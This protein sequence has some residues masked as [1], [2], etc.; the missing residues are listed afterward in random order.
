[1]SADVLERLLQ[2]CEAQPDSVELRQRCGDFCL[3]IDDLDAAE[4]HYRKALEIHSQRTDALNGL[5]VVLARQ[6]RLPEA[7]E[8]LRQVLTLDPHCA[9]AHHN[10]GIALTEQGHI[11]LAITSLQSAIEVDPCYV[12]AHL[13]LANALRT[14]G[15]LK[16]AHA[17]YLSA[18]SL[19]P[20]NVKALHDL[21]TLRTQLK[22]P[23]EA[24]VTLRQVIRLDRDHVDG[25]NSLGL[26]QLAMGEFSEAIASFEHALGINPHWQICHVNLGTAYK[27]SG[28]LNEAIAQ[29]EFAIALDPSNASAH[30]NLSLALLQ[31]GEYERGFAEYEWRQRRIQSPPRTFR[32]PRWDGRSALEGKTLFVHSE[33]GLGDTIQFL[34]FAR[35]LKDGSQAARLVFECPSPLKIIA[36]TC[37]GVDICHGDNEPCPPFDAHFPLLSAPYVFRTTISTIPDRFP[38]LAADLERIQKWRQILESRG[39]HNFRI[40]ICWQ[41]NP[42]HQLDRF[43]SVSLSLFRVLANIDGVSLYCLQRGPG[44]EQLDESA[45]RSLGVI[46]LFERCDSPGA[47]EWAETAAIVRNLDLVICVDT[48]IAHL[49]GSM[50]VAT[51]ILLSTCPDWRWLTIRSDSPWYP[52]V[53]LFRQKAIGRWDGVF[54]EVRTELELELEQAPQHT[55]PPMPCPVSQVTN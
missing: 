31:A 42:H 21:G 29:Y 40:G 10:L 39:D 26:T 52:S 23:E 8:T 2:Q 7:M 27:E 36:A 38:Y 20:G 35:A 25:W 47:E 13:N 5:A 28:R 6:H 44:T 22:R 46:E 41:G 4:L 15:R 50:N 19:Q 1:M 30:W 9:R 32:E 17:R 24:A 18:I 45:N 16:E 54:D 49:A 48:A 11:E 53:R 12:E 51:W 43:R 3:S 33:Q 34:R 37:P 14:A 55:S